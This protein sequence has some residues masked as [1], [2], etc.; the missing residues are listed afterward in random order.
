M[1]GVVCL[2][3]KSP[4]VAMG[5]RCRFKCQLLGTE[6]VVSFL[7]CTASSGTVDQHTECGRM[8]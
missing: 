8:L 6:A 5:E 3:N 1:D 4:S 7:L 2:R